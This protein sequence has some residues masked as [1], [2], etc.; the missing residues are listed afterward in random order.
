[1]LLWGSADRKAVTPMVEGEFS[2]VK[3]R[4]ATLTIG[5]LTVVMEQR[6]QAVA[7]R[8]IAKNQ[9]DD[10]RIMAELARNRNEMVSFKTERGEARFR[11]TGLERVLNFFER[12]CGILKP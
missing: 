1:M 7:K 6:E 5:G 3:A 9:A 4:D 10:A 11:L 12:Q 2:F 8:Y